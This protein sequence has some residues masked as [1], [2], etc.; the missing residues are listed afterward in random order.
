MNHALN[1][2]L[3]RHDT[4]RSWFEY[5]GSGDIV[6]RTITDPADIEFEPIDNGVMA[7]EDARK[8][9]VDIPTPMEWGGC[10][11]SFGVVQSDDHF[12]FFM[13]AS[14]TSTGMRR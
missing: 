9:I 3:R 14:T 2:Y 6:R 12:D 5:A 11:F 13:P 8:H 7:A 1:A 10:F 4:Y